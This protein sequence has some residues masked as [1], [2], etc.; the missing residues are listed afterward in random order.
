MWSKA[1]ASRDTDNKYINVLP[2]GATMKVSSTDAA[3]NLTCR[4][5]RN[6]PCE[7]AG[8]RVEGEGSVCRKPWRSKCGF[9][10][11]AEMGGGGEERGAKSQVLGMRRGRERTKN[12]F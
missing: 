5:W 10:N 8:R 7:R 11:K 6:Q 2:L 1:N 12:S 9:K 3:L 4:M